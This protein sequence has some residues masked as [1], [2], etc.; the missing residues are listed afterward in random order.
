MTGALITLAIGENLGRIEVNYDNCNIL[1]FVIAQPISSLQGFWNRTKYA[2]NAISSGKPTRIWNV[3]AIS[4]LLPV[5]AG[6]QAV[7]YWPT[8]T[9]INAQNND[10]N[11]IRTLVENA[12]PLFEM[13]HAFGVDVENVLAVVE[14]Q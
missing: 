12:R 2:L 5:I 1:A 8:K 11:F 3:I 14:D 10:H 7:G 6:H 13:R 9:I 4:N